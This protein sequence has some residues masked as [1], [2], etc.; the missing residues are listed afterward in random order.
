M[1]EENRP[2]IT[3]EGVKKKKQKV[4]GKLQLSCPKKKETIPR[5]MLHLHK[6]LKKSFRFLSLQ[7][8]HIGHGAQI[9]K[10]RCI[11]TKKGD[12]LAYQLECCARQTQL[13]LGMSDN[14]PLNFQMKGQLMKRWVSC[15]CRSRARMTHDANSEWTCEGCRIVLVIA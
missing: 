3:L 7:M 4:C 14:F 9:S 15:R 2:M 13:R 10:F 6:C 5:V 8:A 12:T 11:S 1:R